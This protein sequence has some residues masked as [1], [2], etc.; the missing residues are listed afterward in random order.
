MD[1]IKAT[2]NNLQK[3]TLISPKEKVYTWKQTT[4]YIGEEKDQDKEY[5]F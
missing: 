5:L 2:N 1:L 3:R 4:L